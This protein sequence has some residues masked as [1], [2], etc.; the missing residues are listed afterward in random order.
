MGLSSSAMRVT[1]QQTGALAVVADALIEHAGNAR[2]G[3]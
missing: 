3:F 1:I 2:A